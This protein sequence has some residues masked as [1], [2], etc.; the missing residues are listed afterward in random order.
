MFRNPFHKGSFRYQLKNFRKPLIL[1]YSVILAL[2]LLM[3][4][5]IGIL[6]Y[7]Y[8]G[9]ELTGGTGVADWALY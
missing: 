6:T 5:G 2:Y 3:A 7:R 9:V 1:F 4:A 8:G